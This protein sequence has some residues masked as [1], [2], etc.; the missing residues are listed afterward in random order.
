MLGY[1]NLQR[2][3]KRRVTRADPIS[4]SFDL[5]L[6]AP[7]RRGRTATVGQLDESIYLKAGHLVV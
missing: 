7:E 6:A 5:R 1:R 3:G 2:L 4:A